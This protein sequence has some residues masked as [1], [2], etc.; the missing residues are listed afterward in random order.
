MVSELRGESVIRSSRHS[1]ALGSR[2]ALLF[3]F[4]GLMWLVFV[5]DSIFGGALPITGIIPRSSAGLPGIIE[6]PFIHANLHHIV[7]NTIPLLILGALILV[8]G[9]GEFLMVIQM[10]MLVGG[11]GTWL[12]GAHG[13]HVGASGIV[14]GF[15]GFLLFR[16]VYD[17]RLSSFF[18]TLVVAFLYGGSIALT[19]LPSAGISWTSHA[20]GFLGGILAARFRYGSRTVPSGLSPA[21]R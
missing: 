11:F 3:G 17:R 14:F 18:M 9:A 16:S 6:A 8:R 2:A 15:I 10:S 20:F 1:E 19:I 7:A 13:A 4:V 5:L 12:F 21:R